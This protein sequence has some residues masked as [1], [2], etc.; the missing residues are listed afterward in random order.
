MRMEQEEVH[1]KVAKVAKNA[2][3]KAFFVFFAFFAT[4]A[5]WFSGLSKRVFCSILQR[6]SPAPGDGNSFQN[7]RII[8]VRAGSA[9]EQA[10]TV[11]TEW[12]V[13]A[14]GCRETSLRDSGLIAAVLDL[15][16]RDLGLTVVGSP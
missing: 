6:Q 7:R 2:K 11:G 8:A 15:V 9:R 14:E 13:D 1:A 4:F 12:V 5:L 3:M 10:M 16:V